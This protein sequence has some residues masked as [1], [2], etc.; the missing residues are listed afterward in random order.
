MTTD[1]GTAPSTQY[2]TYVNGTEYGPYS[3]DQLKQF[4][5]TGNITQN[6][7]VRAD[8]GEW[9]LASAMPELGG[10]FA[11]AAAP[12]Y[13]AP[14]QGYGAPGQQA[15]GVAGQYNG[16]VSDKSFVT[17]LI[18]SVLLGGLGID[19]FYLGYTGL[20]IL[21]LITLGG[22]GIWSLIDLILIAIGK[23]GDSQ[24]RPLA[25]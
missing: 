17:A 1:P 15:Y 25:R 9:V 11:P 6:S 4:A 10:A 12:G 13:P 7:H 14:G 24:G 22:C 21:K 20:G 8:G 3:L 19:R 2:F 16:P 18:L 23:L 5:G